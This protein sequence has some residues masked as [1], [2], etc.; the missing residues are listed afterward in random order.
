MNSGK[1]NFE[2]SIVATATKIKQDGFDSWKIHLMD[3][4]D[5]F[6]RTADPLL[7]LLPPPKDTDARIQSLLASVVQELCSK[8][9]IEVP[10]WAEK[11]YFLEEPW[12]L[13]GMQ[14]L[15]AGAI[16]ES[17]LSFRKNNIFVHDNFLQRV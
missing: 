12:F 6:I 14:S 13:S 8:I 1:S 15:K 16:I 9:D 5:E 4:V 7:I 2:F 3:F 17:P 11:R 10:P